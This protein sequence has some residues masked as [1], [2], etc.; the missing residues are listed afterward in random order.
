MAKLKRR[1]GEIHPPPIA[2]GLQSSGG[3]HGYRKR[4]GVEAHE[5]IYEKHLLCARPC[6][7]SLGFTVD[8][9]SKGLS[10]QTLQ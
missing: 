2:M 1:G 3:E 10:S 9:Q 5:V 4:Q 7:Q 8:G 6:A